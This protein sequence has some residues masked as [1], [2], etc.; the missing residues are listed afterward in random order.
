MALAALLTLIILA[1]HLTTDE[2]RQAEHA[3]IRHIKGGF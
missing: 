1:S 3:G 2:L